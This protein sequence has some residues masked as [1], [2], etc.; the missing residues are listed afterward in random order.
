MTRTCDAIV[1]GLGGFGSAALYELARRGLNVVGIEQF[2]AGHERGSSHGETRIIRRA[3]FEHPDYI[4]LLDHT[5]R[6]WHE[7]EE[8]SGQSLMELCGLVLSGPPEGEAVSGVRLAQ[9]EHQVEIEELDRTTAGDQ[10]PQIRFPDGHVILSETE[11]GYLRV[12]D[13]VRVHLEQAQRHGAHV[14]D[15]ERVTG[16]T[17]D[18]GGVRVQTEH[19]TYSAGRL[20]VATGAWSQQHLPGIVPPLKVIRKPVVWFPLAGPAGKWPV[21]YVE[22]TE[23]RRSFYGLPGLDGNTLKVAEHSGGDEVTDPGSVDRNLAPVESAALQDFVSGRLRG[24]GTTVSRHSVCMYTM[25]PDG[26]FLVDTHPELPEVTLAA[27]FSGHGFKFTPVIGQAL[28][29]LVMDGRTSLPVGF[30]SLE[31]FGQ[32]RH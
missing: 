32:S 21:F 2:K 3:Y 16:W 4:P 20:V 6:L 12:D 27:G 30:L 14:R 23:S 10:F 5:Y 25:T 26:H 13:C 11:A 7:L 15:E 8:E 17:A 9:R 28:A 31:R 24:V 19:D 1:L 22:E 29:D 18:S